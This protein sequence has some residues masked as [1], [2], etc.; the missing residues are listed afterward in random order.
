MLP[1]GQMLSVGRGTNLAGK[2]IFCRDC[3]WEG[4]ST[5][6]QTSLTPLNGST[7]L[8]YTYCCPECAGLDLIIKGK[9]LQFMRQTTPTGKEEPYSLF[10]HGHNK[11]K[12]TR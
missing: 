7:I 9:L 12:L 5:L 6:L 1:R 3:Q 8:L 4:A 2:V 11:K 10:D